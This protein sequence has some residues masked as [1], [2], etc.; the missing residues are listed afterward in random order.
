MDR[1][2]LRAAAFA[3]LALLAGCTTTPE[4]A[5]GSKYVAMGSSF[6][7]GPGIPTYVDDPPAPCARSTMN[8]A[9]QLA[10]RLGLDLVDVGCSGGTTRHL[11]GP[12]DA[13]PPQLDALRADTK[14]VTITIGGNDVS[15]LGRL[16][17]ASCVGLAAE[18]GGAAKCNPIPPVPSEEDYAGLKLRMDQIAAEV[19]K[20]SP[21]ARLV[22]VDYLTIL[23]AGKL[24]KG[25]PL[26][27][28]EAVKAR[29]LA[30]RLADI[31]AKT[32]K[33][34]KAGLIRASDLSA[35]HDAC[36]A[37]P[38]MNGFSRP[39]APVSGTAYHPNKAG[40]TAVADAL[41]KLLR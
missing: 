15:Y 37:V 9:H 10:K 2:I 40:M 33:D 8:Y 16:S 14:L 22:F 20:R 17:A 6:A 24:C 25:A 11:L 34:A 13:I 30:R 39:D 36:A 28:A 35:S 12:R 5:P 19:R 23:P 32:A 29:E 26:S 4:L 3:C 18:T 41:E 27:E 1:T 7:A 31:T 38:W 21:S